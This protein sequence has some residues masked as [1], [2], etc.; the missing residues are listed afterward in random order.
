MASSRGSSK[1][2]SKKGQDD[3]TISSS[4]PSSKRNPLLRSL[5]AKS[6]S[7]STSKKRSDDVTRGI[8]PEADELLEQCEIQGGLTPVFLAEWILSKGENFGS[9]YLL[10]FL[11]GDDDA[12]VG[13]RYRVTARIQSQHQRH[14]HTLRYVLGSKFDN[15]SG[16]KNWHI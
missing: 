16:S 8:V 14:F 13:Y 5:R 15:L 7:G 11:S 4:Q 6:S 3:E 10:P 12:E 2:K 9:V 1:T